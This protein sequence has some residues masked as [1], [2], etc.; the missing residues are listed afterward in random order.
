LPGLGIESDKRN[1]LESGEDYQALFDD[2]SK[3]LPD[4]DPYLKWVYSLLC[5]N[6]RIALMCFEKDVA[7]CHRHVIRDYLTTTHSVMSEDL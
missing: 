5:S 4:L 2:Y 1:S 6:T 3:T 7:M